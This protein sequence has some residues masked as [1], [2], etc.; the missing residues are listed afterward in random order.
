MKEDDAIADKGIDGYS[1]G[2]R[3]SG[4]D[5]PWERRS[6]EEPLFRRDAVWE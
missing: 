5:T 4:R 2:E 1:V 6:L 3:S